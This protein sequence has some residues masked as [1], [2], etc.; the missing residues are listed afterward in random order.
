MQE[1][2]EHLF[3]S[4]FTDSK[5]IGDHS[6][7]A[8]LAAEIGLD[9]S[10]TLQMLGS[11]D[12]A[13]DVRSDEAEANQLGVRG[14][15]FFVINRKYAISGAQPSELFLETLQKVWDEE[16]PLTILNPTG[17]A[18]A[19]AACTDGICTPTAKKS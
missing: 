2:A 18:A 11:E 9:R 16:N 4:Y 6:T 15:P 7:L 17:D 14:V 1:M 12:Y 10:E 8:D 3:H 5:H 19:D 13:A